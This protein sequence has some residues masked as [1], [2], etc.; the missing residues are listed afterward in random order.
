MKAMLA[1]LTAI[2]VLGALLVALSSMRRR[3]T[4]PGQDDR[5]EGHHRRSVSQEPDPGRG[6]RLMIPESVKFS[7]ADLKPGADV[8][9]A[10]EEKTVKRS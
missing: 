8:K 6:T 4:G 9:A 10:Y 2:A 3:R 5:G 1:G 7:R